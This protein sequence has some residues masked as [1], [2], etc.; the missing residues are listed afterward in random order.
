MPYKGYFRDTFSDAS[1]RF[2]EVTCNN[3]GGASSLSCTG[4][5]SN[6]SLSLR[7]KTILAVSILSLLIALRQPVLPGNADEV[8]HQTLA[9][10][11][12]LKRVQ[13]QYY[14][15]VNYSS[16]SYRNELSGN[17]YLDFEQNSNPTGFW[18]QT[19]NKLD[20]VIYN[21]QT[22]LTMN[23]AEKT[24]RVEKQPGINR[25]SSMSCFYNSIVTMRNSLKSIAGDGQ[26]DKTLADT[27]VN[28]KACYQV[29]FALPSQVLDNLGSFRK[30]T[31]ERTIVYKIVVDKHSYLPALVLQ[32]N[33]VT[34]QDYVLTR[35]WDYRLAGVKPSATSWHYL[36]YATE[37]KP[38]LPK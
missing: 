5:A 25:F 23:E 10:L 1:G 20:K 38:I 37:Y 32:T 30:L 8:L 16:E 2:E 4:W 24:M 3:S 21:G 31:T 28:G 36:T 26:I 34:P 6:W 29:T 18:F 17:L 7:M 33:N 22:L 11:T 35:F 13:Y 14:R 12:A 19:D 15:E 9:K 27:I